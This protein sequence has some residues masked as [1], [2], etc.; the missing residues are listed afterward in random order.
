[1]SGRTDDAPIAPCCAD[2]PGA[3]SSGWSLPRGALADEEGA[4]LPSQLPPVVDAHVHVFPDRLLAAIQRWFATH[5]WPVRYPLP[6]DAVVPFLLDRGVSRVVALTYAHKPGIAR[7]LNRFMAEVVRREPRVIGCGT[8]HP[9]DVDRVAVVEEAHALGL[10]GVKLH[11][12][13]QACAID[14]PRLFPVYDACARLALP[15]VV[16]AGR[17]PTSPAYPVDPYT[18]CGAERTGRVLAAFPALRLVVPHLG[19]DEFDAYLALLERHDNLWLDTTMAV[20]GYFAGDVPWRI[21]EARPDRVLYGTDFPNLPYAWDREVLRI[22]E[23]LGDEPLAQILGG[24]A[25][26]LYGLAP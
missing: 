26:G 4:R 6:A 16:H 23:R 11:C 1:M 24:N 21:L 15:L 13:V 14:D 17:E 2:A 25:A 12:H 5:G 20:A 7:D 19:A 10:R 3:A 8:V 18:I 22:A 9:D